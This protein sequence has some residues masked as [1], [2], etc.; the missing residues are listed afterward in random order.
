MRYRQAD[1]RRTEILR[2]AARSGYVAS[3]E[4]AVALD[5]SEM[6]VRRDI[7]KLAA[8]GALER[9]LG[10]ARLAPSA[11]PAFGVRERQASD[12][13]RAI[14]DHAVSL[15]SPGTIGL[16]SGTTVALL[17]PALES[18]SCVVTHSAPVIHAVEDRADLDLIVAGGVYQRTTRS[19]VGPAVL[20]ALEGLALDVAVISV[21]GIDDGWLLGGD[22]LDAAVKRAL[23][24]A[25]RRVIVVA[26]GS[27]IGARAAIRLA[28][29]DA[30]H[31]LVTDP[32]GA[33]ALELPPH[34]TLRIAVA[35]A[36]LVT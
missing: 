18:G 28:R 15:L 6:T 9:V 5:V 24:A 26:D 36:A 10:G 35:P 20:H 16:D 11:R 30:V 21:A 19:F 14:A 4:L 7:D 27:K 3:G 8:D 23:M 33:R 32:D 22:A 25:A 12:A 17:A 29:L 34:S 2:V 1:A 13:K 31:D